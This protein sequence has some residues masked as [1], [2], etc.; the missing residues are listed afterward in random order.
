MKARIIHFMGGNIIEQLAISE[1]QGKEHFGWQDG[2]SQPNV[3]L[4]Q[5]DVDEEAE[6]RQ[7]RLFAGEFVFGYPTGSVG[8]GM[9][10]ARQASEQAKDGTFMVVR[11]LG[12]NVAAFHRSLRDNATGG[13]SPEETGNRAVGRKPVSNAK[14]CYAGFRYLGFS[15]LKQG[16]DPK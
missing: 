2:V 13:I 1:L 16:R 12:Q 11:K 10:N 5:K 7:P 9:K 15:A 8:E 4:T 6:D 14:I 3:V